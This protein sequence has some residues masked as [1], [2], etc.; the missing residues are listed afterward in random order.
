MSPRTGDPSGNKY[1]VFARYV[2]SN[3]GTCKYIYLKWVVNKACTSR[4]VQVHLQKDGN[5]FWRIS[6][7][8]KAK[9]PPF[10]RD[11]GDLAMCCE[12]CGFKM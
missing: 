5:W 2:L 8:H 6:P 11:P 10:L 1:P 12:Q 4:R 7:T 9:D 3:T